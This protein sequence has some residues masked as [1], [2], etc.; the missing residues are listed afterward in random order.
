MPKDRRL[1][2]NHVD[3]LYSR[4]TLWLVLGVLS[5]LVGWYLGVVIAW[6]IAFFFSRCA[7]AGEK[8]L[9]RQDR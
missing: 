9:E 4:S 7:V 3:L 2:R 6:C 5:I 1:T 8:I